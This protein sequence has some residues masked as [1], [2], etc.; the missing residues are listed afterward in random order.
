M[1]TSAGSRVP[2]APVGAALP[3]GM[4]RPCSS[5]TL[6]GLVVALVL[7]AAPSACV[8]EPRMRLRYA[9]VTGVR[10]SFPPALGVLMKLVVDV[11][12]PNSYDVAVRAVRGRV[13]MADRYAMPVDFKAQ[14][15]GIWLPAGRTTQVAVPVDV[16]IQIALAVLR[17]STATAEIPYRFVGRAD[18]TATRTFE[19]E[20]D[21][22]SVDARGTVSRKQIQDAVPF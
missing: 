14:G 6:R 11:Y 20:K 4:R 1:S 5:S 17:E 3:E 2:F 10:V 12:N 8:S 19:L 13:T 18:V 16:P 7:L 9:E 15:D 22:Y 21:D